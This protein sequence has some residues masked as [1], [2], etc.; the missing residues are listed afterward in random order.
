MNNILQRIK[1]GPTKLPP[2]I[3]LIGV[4]GVGKSTAGAQMPNPVFICGESGLVG[5]QF[6]DVPNYTPE[7]WQDVLDFVDALAADP[8]GY[9]SLVID[10]L[11]WIE[12][13]LYAHVV[14]AQNKPEYKTI[15]DIPFG[16]GTPLAQNEARKLIVR[17]DKVNAAGMNVLILSHSQQKTVKNP[18]GD[19]YDHFESSVNAKICGIFKQWVDEILFARFEVFTETKN[20]RVRAYGGNMRIVETEHSAA[21][22]AKN[23]YGLPEQMP[24]DMV[25]IMEAITKG[26]GGDAKAAEIELRG[27]LERLPKDKADK[28]LKWLETPPSVVDLQKVLN[29]V[30]NAIKEAENG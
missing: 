19:D 26:N 2:K 3:M 27:L 22:D 28:T 23:R 16:R 13:L 14:S 15:A 20:N 7:N 10:T 4:E 18:L 8:S 24:L 25:A 29:N 21:W 5:H 30:K 1:K 11:D 17:L 9:K 6:A 12:P